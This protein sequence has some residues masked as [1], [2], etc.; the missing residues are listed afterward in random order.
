MAWCGQCRFCNFTCWISATESLKQCLTHLLTEHLT[1]L[2]T[3]FNQARPPWKLSN[4]SQPMKL[5]SG[6]T[7]ASS[8]C[9]AWT[10]IIDSSWL[11]LMKLTQVERH[12]LKLTDDLW[13]FMR[14]SW[15]SERT[16]LKLT[17]VVPMFHMEGGTKR[18]PAFLDWLT[19]G[20][21]LVWG[22]TRDCAEH[23]H[24]RSET[25]NCP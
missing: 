17:N 24:F 23:T 6:L 18:N 9:V 10:S 5:L 2:L 16:W 22:V 12:L 4:E 21:L 8:G 25:A 19:R 1:W 13:K 3:K 11:K 20:C 14:K 7:L 15:E